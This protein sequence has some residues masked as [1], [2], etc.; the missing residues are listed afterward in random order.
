[1]TKLT[2]IGDIFPGDEIFTVGFGIK[3]KST[4]DRVHQWAGNISNT[5]GKADYIV[6]NLESPLIDKLFA[7]NNT[8]FG[9][10]LFANVLKESG[11]NVLSIANNHILEHGTEGFEQTVRLL[12]DKG[13]KT[14]GQ[15]ENGAPSILTIKH[16]DITICLS[17]FCDEKVCNIENPRCYASL[18]END[19]LETLEKMKANHA[20]II[21]FVFHWGNEYIQMPSLEQKALAHKLIDKGANLIIGH[22]PHVIQPYEKYHGGHIV[23]SL[24]NFCFDD[25]QSEHFGRGMAVKIYVEGKAIQDITFTG[26]SVQDMAYG[27]DLVRPMPD[28][29]FK[30]YFADINNEYQKVYNL[31]DENYQKLYDA[32]LQKLHSRERVQMRKDI[33]KKALD[34]FHRHK[35]QFLKN[36]INF[37]TNH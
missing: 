9:S 35:V 24:G 29:S 8:F 26:I 3:S 1:M 32:R 14:I 20:D 27:D 17:G 36:I 25:V 13:I 2:F 4:L 28:K 5:I 7:K 21:I 11:V 37:I 6:G 33:I 10:T 16:G 12:K 34:P 31:S 22:H 18:V 15:N 23:Y 19:I 30:Q